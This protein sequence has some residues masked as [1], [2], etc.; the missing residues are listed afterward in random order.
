MP[1]K[2]FSE[3]ELTQ[4]EANAA[5]EG[6][7]VKKILRLE[8]EAKLNRRGE[9]IREAERKWKFAEQYEKAGNTA[10]MI[11]KKLE[12]DKTFVI[13]E[14]IQEA[15]DALCLY[16]SG[17][18]RF[19]KYGDLNKG[20]CLL[21]YVGTGKTL[22]MHAFSRNTRQCFDVVSAQA[23]VDKYLEQ[24]KIED[25]IKV[26]DEYSVVPNA[27]FGDVSYFMQN[28][29]ALC[30]DDIGSE[31]PMPVNKWG[32]IVNIIEAIIK[33]RYENK[34]PFNMTHFVSNHQDFERV[35]GTRAKDRI[36]QMVNF[37]C[38]NGDSRR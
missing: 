38:I 13:D 7:K 36:N 24:T 21:G 18:E 32:N 20:I 28:K 14:T 30:I 19:S 25:A 29:I 31:L 10:A 23:I 17:D 5:L 33:R 37:I 8:E 16:F 12:P 4:E 26:I 15:F 27:F 22:L 11:I 1:Q 2:D 6:A 3:V 9:L 34:I 35:Y